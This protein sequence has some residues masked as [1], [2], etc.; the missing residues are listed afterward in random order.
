MTRLAA[1]L[2]LALLAPLA[3]VQLLAL[4]QAPEPAK[5]SAGSVDADAARNAEAIR[6]RAPSPEQAGAPAK[7]SS[8]AQAMLQQAAGVSRNLVDAGRIGQRRAVDPAVQGLAQSLV[9]RHQALLQEAEAIAK[10]HGL[11][12][13]GKAT[14]N[15]QMARLSRTGG[16]DTVFVREVGI[17]M[18]TQAVAKLGDQAAGGN[19]A[20]L[21]AWHAKYVDA[22]REGL[23]TAQRIPLRNAPDK[24]PRSSSGDP[25]AP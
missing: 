5:K 10:E 16:F 13:G 22:L 24:T 18:Q 19:D 12:L 14:A 8:E 3:S 20:E 9:V 1:V 4:A 6:Q 7:L 21:S 25:A 23:S 11:R 2:T 15:A 17:D